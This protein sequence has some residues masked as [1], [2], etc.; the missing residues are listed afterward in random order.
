MAGYAGQYG[1]TFHSKCG[2]GEDRG[3]VLASGVALRARTAGRGRS[4]L[5]ERLPRAG[6]PGCT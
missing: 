3:L 4:R 5:A 6:R 2:A 1:E